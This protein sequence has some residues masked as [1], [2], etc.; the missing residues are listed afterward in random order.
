[1]KNDDPH[2]TID[3]ALNMIERHLHGIRRN[4]PEGVT[5]FGH[6]LTKGC[7]TL[8]RGAGFCADCHEKKLAKIVGATAAELFHKGISI[9]RSAYSDMRRDICLAAQNPQLDKLLDEIEESE[10]LKNG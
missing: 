5:T 10:A 1:M 9:S 7:N 2:K 6:C 8:A 3:R 4:Y